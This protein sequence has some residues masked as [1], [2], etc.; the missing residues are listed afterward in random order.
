M[1]PQPWAQ[2]R[3][4]DRQ[5][6]LQAVEERHGNME[7][8]DMLSTKRGHRAPQTECIYKHRYLSTYMIM[9]VLMNNITEAG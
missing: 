9:C 8:P 5:L 3:T 4:T 7:T 2:A 6:I 1:L